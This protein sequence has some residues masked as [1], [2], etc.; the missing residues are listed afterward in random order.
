MLKCLYD[1]M[2]ADFISFVVAVIVI[3]IFITALLPAGAI[4]P[5]LRTTL[6]HVPLNNGA[7]KEQ[8]CSAVIITKDIKPRCVETETKSSND[9]LPF[10]S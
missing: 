5:R 10:A 3:Y 8:R 7:I 1:F 9:N 2:P 6:S 4:E